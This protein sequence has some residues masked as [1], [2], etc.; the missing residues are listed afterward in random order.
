VLRLAATGA[1]SV[2]SLRAAEIFSARKFVAAV[3]DY[4]VTGEAGSDEGLQLRNLQLHHDHGKNQEG[5][6]HIG[7][8]HDAQ[9]N[10]PEWGFARQPAF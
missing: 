8:D 3:I 5:L 2:S 10:Q 4:V 1:S 6:Q 7:G 9:G